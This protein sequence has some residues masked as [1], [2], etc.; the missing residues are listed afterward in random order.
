VFT[1]SVSAGATPVV[2][3]L[4][5]AGRKVG[6]LTVTATVSGTPLAATRIARIKR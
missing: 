1:R 6:A 5:K 3:T 4:P 2:V